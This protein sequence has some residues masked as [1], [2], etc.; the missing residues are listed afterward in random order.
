MPARNQALEETTEFVG[1]SSL[2]LSSMNSL[3]L[4]M[5]YGRCRITVDPRSLETCL[6]RQLRR[7]PLCRGFLA[8]TALERYNLA[9]GRHLLKSIQESG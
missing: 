5:V 3:L 9:W 2:E 1:T 8:E 4:R 7:W 6:C